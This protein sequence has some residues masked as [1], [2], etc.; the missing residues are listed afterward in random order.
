MK[1]YFK[2]IHL[3]LN[4][5]MENNNDIKI[6]TNNFKNI[7][8]LFNKNNSTSDLFSNKILLEK[9]KENEN[10]IKKNEIPENKK[11]HYL[12]N[13]YYAYLYSTKNSDKENN[14][15]L[16]NTNVKNNKISSSNPISPSQ[17][18]KLKEEAKNNTQIYNNLFPDDLLIEY[19]NKKRLNELRDKYLSNSSLRFLRKKDESKFELDNN[20]III[21]NNKRLNE[22]MD[23]NEKDMNNI[24]LELKLNYEKLQNEFN[25]LKDNKNKEEKYFN[26]N[27]VNKE[28]DN[29]NDINK[30]DKDICC[31]YLIEEN[32]K[33]KKINNKY[34]IILELLI[35][36][37][38]ETNKF[39][40]FK[41]IDY[42]NLKQNIFHTK[43][44]CIKE[45]SNFLNICKNDLDIKMNLK[46]LQFDKIATNKKH[47]YINMDNINLIEI[48]KNKDNHKDKNN[49]TDTHINKKRNKIRYTLSTISFRNK[50]NNSS[51][52]S[53]NL[54]QSKT[55]TKDK[56]SKSRIKLVK[57]R[58]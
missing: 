5:N 54:K 53:F 7:P 47:K 45:L 9:E 46:T 27:K 48:Y 56:K 52:E 30:K 16:I 25:K 14:T 40:H 34:E 6:L 18:I 31:N 29:E 21:N 49:N 42:F 2:Y 38:N 44:K 11:D 17:N 20:N 1:I 28:I 43:T 55:L 51:M 33:L 8:L 4:L 22:K 23:L 19:N 41:Q 3:N 10:N 37:I 15:T 26:K 13:E 24:I 58:K 12:T 57:K 39:F 35:S 50:Y 36:Y 32:N